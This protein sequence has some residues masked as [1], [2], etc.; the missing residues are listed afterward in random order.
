[1]V[2][3]YITRHG[4]TVWNREKRMQ[5]W[6]N[7]PLTEQG[8]KDAASLGDRLRS[9]EF[10]AVYSSPSGRAQQTT[11]LIRGERKIP[12]Y[13]EEKLKE[14]HLGEWEGRTQEEI[15]TDFPESFD[16]FWN[17]PHRYLPHGGETFEAFRS[18]IDAFLDSLAYHSNQNVLIVA[19]AV[20]I[21][22]MMLIL[23]GKP[24]AS[25]WDP[26]FI[27]GTSVTVVRLEDGQCEVLL[28]GDTSH[29]NRNEGKGKAMQ[30]VR[31]KEKHDREMERIIKQS[32]ESFGLD[33]PGTAYYDPEL[34][35]LS[36]FY[37]RT[38]FAEYWVALD[39]SGEVLGGVGIA[40]FAEEEGVCELQKLY[41]KPEAQGRGTAKALMETALDY[42]ARHYEYCYLETVEKLE[43]ANRLYRKFGFSLLEEALAGSGHGAMD[44]WY[45][46]KL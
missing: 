38:P 1:M 29:I 19:H 36:H 35:H 5:G 17:A 10:A 13:L 14:I 37:E 25:L 33:I 20:V 31:M 28:E 2:T 4:E 7:S 30:I 11:E 43:A 46:K 39:D 12:V 16:M 32:L 9:T 21:K 34:P 8:E 24:L 6:Q 45:K 23:N 22:C 27:H 3:I 18:R 41:V 26:P 40:P 44:S 15:K 42:A